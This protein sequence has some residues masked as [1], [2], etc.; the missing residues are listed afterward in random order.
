MTDALER[1]VEA[2][3]KCFHSEDCAEGI[4]AFLEKRQPRFRGR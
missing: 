2:Q 3:L 4:R 1:E